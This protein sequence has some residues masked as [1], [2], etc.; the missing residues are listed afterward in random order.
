M[1]ASIRNRFVLPILALG[2]DAAGPEQSGKP[3]IAAVVGIAEFLA[4]M[5]HG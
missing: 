5:R 4:N 1:A 2:F 3:I